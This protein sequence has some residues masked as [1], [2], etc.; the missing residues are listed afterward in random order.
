M[1]PESVGH[2][3]GI[4]VP[5]C[6]RLTLYLQ[7][8][9]QTKGCLYGRQAG[10]RTG[11]RSNYDGTVLDSVVKALAMNVGGQYHRDHSIAIVEAQKR[12]C[13]RRVK[14]MVNRDPLPTRNNHIS[15]Q[16]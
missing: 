13:S 8:T 2:Y 9:L 10:V 6:L 15:A 5:A 12:I 16:V 3:G 4:A 11:R 1:G 7:L 14:T